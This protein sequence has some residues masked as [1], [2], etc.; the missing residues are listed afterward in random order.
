MGLAA[1]RSCSLL[2]GHFRSFRRFGPVALL[3]VC[4]WT[5]I[6]H[7]QT[8]TNYVTY[9]GAAQVTTLGNLPP[10]V[11]SHSDQMSGHSFTEGVYLQRDFF[12]TQTDPNTG[13][14]TGTASFDVSCY[15]QPGTLRVN[16]VGA[17]SAITTVPYN[18][19]GTSANASFGVVSASW[20]D[21][22]RLSVPLA[23]PGR[24]F[25]FHAFLYLDGSLDLNVS[26][27]GSWGVGSG[28][29]ALALSGS[30]LPPAPYAGG[31]WGRVVRDIS[32]P[33]NN[34]TELPGTAI[35]VAVPMPNGEFVGFNY[36]MFVT[37]QNLVSNQAG[38]LPPGFGTTDAFFAASFGQSLTWGGIISVTDTQT[39]Q[40]VT[41]WTITSSSGFDY[42]QPAPEPAS[43]LM[44]GMGCLSL[45]AIGRRR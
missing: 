40:P 44:V 24:S 27:S 14:A 5:S 33:A 30:G 2:D 43:G 6:T 21:T 3:V 12:A 17:V 8:F 37:G 10:A 29:L 35:P 31:Y 22:A 36:T 39:G 34:R 1:D 18:F 11:D 13:T 20:A 28:D 41:D 4:S 45:A 15:A 32:N 42:S 25:T 19:A 23:E 7:A 16:A 38:F 26:K 9:S